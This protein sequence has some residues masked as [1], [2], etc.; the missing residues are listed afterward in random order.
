MIRQ[1]AI[2]TVLGALLESANLSGALIPVTDSNVLSGLSPNDVIVSQVRKAPVKNS[3]VQPFWRT[4]AMENEPVLFVQEASAFESVVRR[5]R[6]AI[7]AACH[8]ADIVLVAPMTGNPRI[9]PPDRFL[10]RRAQ[11]RPIRWRRAVSC[12]SAR[13]SGRSGGAGKSG[14]V[15]REA[16]KGSLAWA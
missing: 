9:F 13:Q 4:Q 7:Q 3:L 10:L 12:A 15:R 2:A 6:D 14:R 1:K 16:Q 11:S 8:E 5:L